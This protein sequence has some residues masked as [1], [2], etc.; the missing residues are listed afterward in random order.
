MWCKSPFTEGQIDS[1]GFR[2]IIHSSFATQS[3]SIPLAA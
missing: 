2:T 1:C 3:F